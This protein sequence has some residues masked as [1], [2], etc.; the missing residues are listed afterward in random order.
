MP[1][2]RFGISEGEKERAKMLYE[3]GVAIGTEFGS[4]T[5]GAYAGQIQK[6][7]KSWGYD[8]IGD[9]YMYDYLI[10]GE[11]I[12]KNS[13][14]IVSGYGN[15]GG[16]VWIVDGITVTSLPCSSAI[17]RLDTPKGRI[18]DPEG[19]ATYLHM[20]WGAGGKDNAWYLVK[21]STNYINSINNYWLG[22]GE[23]KTFFVNIY[24]NNGKKLG[25]Y[26]GR[27]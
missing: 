14:V 21:E 10:I 8:N 13:P 5:S 4:P 18:P 17:M 2:D 22:F 20:N 27:L 1:Y 24:H 7:F 25:S 12:R 16:H 3:I 11:S 26:N 9:T 19:S 23:Q 15:G 6:L